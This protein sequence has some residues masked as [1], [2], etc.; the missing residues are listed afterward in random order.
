MVCLKP[1]NRDQ[2][3]APT[4]LDRYET[5]DMMKRLVIALSALAIPTA[6]LSHHSRAEFS[7][8]TVE[9][10]GVLTEVIWRNPHIALQLEV[11]SEGG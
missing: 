2:A 1:K 4:R 8:E 6:A 3:V 11:R 7:D 9:I 5:I 10:A